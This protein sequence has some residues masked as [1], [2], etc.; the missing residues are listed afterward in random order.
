MICALPEEINNCQFCTPDMS[1]TNPDP[2]C[3]FRKEERTEAKQ[4]KWFEKYY[5]NSKAK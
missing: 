3:G 1:C 5:K 2:G 4:E